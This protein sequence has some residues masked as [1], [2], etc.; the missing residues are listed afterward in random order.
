MLSSTDSCIWHIAPPLKKKHPHTSLVGTV[1]SSLYL[2]VYTFIGLKILRVALLW[3]YLQTWSLLCSNFDRILH[4]WQEKKNS[5]WA[6]SNMHISIIKYLH[7]QGLKILKE[8][9]PLPAPILS[10]GPFL[11]QCG[12]SSCGSAPDYS[13]LQLTGG[14]FYRHLPMSHSTER[15]MSSTEQ[16]IASEEKEHTATY[17]DGPQ[18]TE[19]E[20]KT[21]CQLQLSLSFNGPQHRIISYKLLASFHMV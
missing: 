4:R 14:H 8:K 13:Y 17:A 6:L 10:S 19:E 1:I 2:H 3:R 9:R 12:S 5:T 11:G 15:N 7:S 16:T 21:S 18:Y 20:R